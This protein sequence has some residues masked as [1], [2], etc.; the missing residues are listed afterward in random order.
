MDL[1]RL[2]A[3]VDRL[4]GA[5]KRADTTTPLMWGEWAVVQ[6]PNI[7]SVVLESDWQQ[8]PRPVRNAAGRLE[9]YQRVWVLHQGP[10]TTI[11]AAPTPD[12]GWVAATVESGISG[13]LTV[14]KIGS[15]VYLKGT[16]SYSGGWP[17]RYTAAA[18]LPA[19]ARPTIYMRVALPGYASGTAN[20]TV[21]GIETSGVMNIASVGALNAAAYLTG[22]SWLTD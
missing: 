9:Q 10:I 17:T 8:T 21:A 16:L 13:T 5:V 14:R 18:M 1:S 19:W 3:G 20:S 11:V 2:R 6:N 22:L 4:A 12:T 7:P 15:Q